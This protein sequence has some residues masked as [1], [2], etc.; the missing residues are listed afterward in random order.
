MQLGRIDYKGGYVSNLGISF[1]VKSNDSV[2]FTF[3]QANNAL[4]LEAHDIS[5]AITGNFKQKLLLISATGK[6]KAS[7]KDGG[8]SLYITVPLHTQMV[9]GRQIPKIDVSQLQVQ[10]DTR[11]ITISIWGGFLADIGDIFIGLFKSTIIHSIGNSINGQLPPKINA[12][13]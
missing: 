5:G 13:I 4:H 1:A 11:K 8:I 6:F 9:N 3:D 2:Q 7:F 12:A 10:F